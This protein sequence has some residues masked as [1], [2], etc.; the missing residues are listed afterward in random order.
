MPRMPSE[1]CRAAVA[2]KAPFAAT[3]ERT[4]AALSRSSQGTLDGAALVAAREPAGAAPLGPATNSATNAEANT[5]VAAAA[6]ARLADLE[7]TQSSS[8]R[9]G[10]VVGGGRA[11]AN[12]RGAVRRPLA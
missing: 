4:A 1:R 7:R 8:L 9:L 10:Q 11:R 3:A 12:A 2:D 6:R 5:P